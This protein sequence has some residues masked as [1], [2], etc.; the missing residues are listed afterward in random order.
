[1][2]VIRKKIKPEYF[3]AVRAREKNFELRKDEDGIQAGD[4]LILEEWNNGYTGNS[5]RRYIKYVLR[6]VP[7]YGLTQGYCIIGW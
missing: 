4:L 6:N 7:E 3:R 2:N 5:V 1:M